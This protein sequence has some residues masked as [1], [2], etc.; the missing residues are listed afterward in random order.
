MMTRTLFSLLKNLLK[1]C[2]KESLKNQLN[3]FIEIIKING[4]L[5]SSFDTIGKYSTF[6]ESIID[7]ILNSINLLSNNVDSSSESKLEF[8]D[9]LFSVDFLSLLFSAL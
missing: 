2:L 9:E 4:L 8:E 1:S 5:F 7:S 3:R 6:S